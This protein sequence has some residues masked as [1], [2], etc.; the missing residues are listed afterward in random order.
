MSKIKELSIQLTNQIAAGEVVERPASVVKELVENAIDAK[1]TSIIIKLKSSGLESIE[2]IDNGE[3]MDETDAVRAFD[4]YATSK[5]SQQ[6]DLFRIK[7]LGFRGEALPSIASVSVIEL[8]T[9]DGMNGTGVN[10]AFGTIKEVRKLAKK[11]GTS[12][13]VSQLFGNTPAR[14]R[15]MKT[16]QTELKHIIDYVNRLALSRSDIQFEVWHDEQL[17]MKTPGNEQLIQAI[18]GIYTPKVAR[19]LLHISGE[20][21]DFKVDGYISPPLLSRSNRHYISLLINGRYVKHFPLFQAI[22]RGY[23]TTL[24]TRRY[25]IVVLSVTTDPMLVDVNVHPSKLDIRLS[26]SEQLE[27]LLIELIKSKVQQTIR[28]PES[29]TSEKYVKPIRRVQDKLDLPFNHLEEIHHNNPPHVKQLADMKQTDD[30]DAKEDREMTDMELNQVSS[31]SYNASNV[32]E[33]IQ[34]L[35]AKESISENYKDYTVEHDEPTTRQTSEIND[36]LKNTSQLPHLEYVGQIHGTYLIAQSEDGFYLID[37]H[38]AKER[39]Q[40]EKTLKRLSHPIIKQQ[41]LLLP[42]IIHLSRDEHLSALEKKSIFEQLGILFDDF[43]GTDLIFNSYP[44]WMNQQ[45]LVNDLTFIVSQ[46][47]HGTVKSIQDIRDSQAAMISC[48]SS[49]RANHYIND[50]EASEL[51]SELLTVENPFNCPH[52]RPTIVHFSTYEIERLFKRIQD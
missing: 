38:A 20:K 9:S 21:D 26:K 32:D 11:K 28:I 37:Q 4:R 46:V 25:P 39:I 19:Q 23:G 15:F 16:L 24:M 13:K 22:E 27:Q 31:Y 29:N 30:Y 14:L 17:L 42:E 52:G 2:I 51:I 36:Q 33:P 3:G 35:I 44:N 8:E 6:E 34:T 5:I 10:I 50:H 1:A 41:Q 12:I 40:Y 49:I 7:T 43:G 47:V 18:A 45:T 48:K